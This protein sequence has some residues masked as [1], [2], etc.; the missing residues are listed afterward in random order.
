MESTIAAVGQRLKAATS[1]AVL[2]GAGISAE[3]GIPTFRDP[4]GLWQQ[5]RP[6]DLATPEAFRRDPRLVWE[7][8]DWRRQK[9]AAASPNPGHHALAKM[10]TIFAD[11][12]L[13][14]QNIDGLHRAAGSQN[15][16]ELHGCIWQVRCLAEGT[17]RENREVPLKVLPPSCACGSLLRPDVVWFGEPLSGETQAQAF[18]AAGSPDAFLTVGTSALVQPAASL[19]LLAKDRGAFVVE[20]NPAPTPITPFVDRHLEGHAGSIL[21][22]IISIL[23]QG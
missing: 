15:L 4:G 17:I 16:V 3:S 23:T 2:T 21:P 1:V 11:F 7:W 12:I 19:P 14:T 8:Y 13:I 6:E 22:Q 5:Y 20:I 18:A 9:I 10:E